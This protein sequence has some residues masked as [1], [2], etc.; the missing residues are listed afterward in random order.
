MTGLLS[1][2]FTAKATQPS[3]ES[4]GFTLPTNAGLGTVTETLGYF[5]TELKGQSVVDS[6][7]L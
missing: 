1:F 7:P 6:S 2:R 3:N 4:P 5:I